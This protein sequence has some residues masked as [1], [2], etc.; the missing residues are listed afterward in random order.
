MNA[1][2]LHCGP[3][4]ESD[5][6][7]A[8][9]SA[10]KSAFISTCEPWCKSACQST[11]LPVITPSFGPA[12]ASDI[13]PHI[14]PYRALASQLPIL[15]LTPAHSASP[16]VADRPRSHALLFAPG[17]AADSVAPASVAS[18]AAEQAAGPAGSMSTRCPGRASSRES[19]GTAIPSLHPLA[20]RSG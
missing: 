16:T 5:Y 15:P 3:L 12:V 6:K 1:Q 9:T 17:R 13:E 2:I 14:T 8:F 19:F 20:T 7:S 11:L 4:C 10:C 18:H